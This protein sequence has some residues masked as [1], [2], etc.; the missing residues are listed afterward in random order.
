MIIPKKISVI[1]LGKL[2]SCFSACFAYRGFKVLGCDINQEIVNSI[3]IHKAPFYEKNLQELIDKSYKNLKA[4]TNFTEAYNFSD[5]YFFIVPTPSNKDGSFSNEFLKKALLPFAQ[6]LNK[7]KKFKIFVITSTVSPLSIQK[8]IIPFIEKTSS[9]KFNKNFTVVYNPT[10][11]AIGDIIKGILEPDLVLIGEN[12]KPSGEVISKIWKKV[13]LNKPFISRMSIV[14]AEITKIAINSYLTIKISF[15]NMLGNICEKIEGAEI[16]K[17]TEAMGKD[18]RIN[19]YYLKYGTAYGGP[20]FPRDNKAFNHF[21]KSVGISALIPLAAHKTNEF[22][23]KFLRDKILKIV[24]KYKINNISILGL[25][26]K[27]GAYII[28][29]SASINL[30]KE[31]LKQNKNLK[32]TVYDPLEI[33][34]TETQKVFKDRLNYAKSLAESLLNKLILIMTPD[35]YFQRINR[36]KLKDKILIDCWR[37]IKV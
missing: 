4:T 30:I 7:D 1:G 37:K 2:G 17:I 6:N 3:N 24:K 31:L 33:N 13:C 16:D 27:P 5:I 19:P 34:I 18:K 36:N 12:H 14:S 10:F 8:E 26:Y 22:Q 21:A 20:C 11:I 32:I 23:T 15:A 35:E 9:K 25:S 28:E 29:E